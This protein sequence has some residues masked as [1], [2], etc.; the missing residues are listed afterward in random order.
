MTEEAYLENTLQPI[1]KLTHYTGVLI[2]W[3][4][5]EPENKNL[6][7]KILNR[8]IITLV[9]FILFL[10]INF[11][12][13]Q[14]I[15]AIINMTSI[16]SVTPN[17]LW[18][19]VYP[20]PL[21]TFCRFIFLRRAI[22]SFFYD[23]DIFEIQL[24]NLKLDTESGKSAKRIRNYLFS[25][26]FL[27]HAFVLYGLVNLMLN[28]PQAPFL[29]MHY[30]VLNEMFTVPFLIT[31]HIVSFLL[32][33]TFSMMAE[34]VPGLTFYHAALNLERIKLQISRLFSTLQPSLISSD[35][36]ANNQQ[37]K[38]IFISQTQTIW[39][40]YETVNDLVKRAN[41]LFGL[42]MTVALSVNFF[43]ICLGMYSALANFKTSKNTAA[44]YLI[45]VFKNLFLL[46]TSN[47]LSSK[48]NSS[49]N[50]LNA[51]FASQLSLH[52]HLL[53]EEEVE[54]VAA[55]LYR[56]QEEPIVARPLNLYNV[57][58]EILLTMASLV[59]SYVIVLLQA[60]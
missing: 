32:G 12:F 44:N 26:Y 50:E 39:K 51:K 36:R 56:L 1:W 13:I 4:Y 11:E 27:I 17:V 58:H 59:V 16:H 49:F 37:P 22:A 45:T 38:S 9:F 48:L 54:V 6:L 5:I 3:F 24:L 15:I 57:T 53:A 23:W 21:V 33:W 10:L 30:P 35:S 29:F 28:K 25:A 18:F 43:L 8:L 31:L 46:V 7:V 34:V 14:L 41:K 60:K 47:L 19:F 55:F 42:L 40:H 2:D 20:L 52:Y